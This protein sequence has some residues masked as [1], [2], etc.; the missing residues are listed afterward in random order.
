MPTFRCSFSAC[1][2]VTR[3]LWY[4]RIVTGYQHTIP[5]PQAI[6]AVGRVPPLLKDYAI[7]VLGFIDGMYL[8]KSCLDS[9]R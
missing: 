8:A 6:A 2:Y 3:P 7:L 9:L 5:A 4:G 1:L